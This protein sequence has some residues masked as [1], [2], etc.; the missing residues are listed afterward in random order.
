MKAYNLTAIVGH[1]VAILG[2][3][4]S[5]QSALNLLNLFRNQLVDLDLFD[6]THPDFAPISI[7]I[8]SQKQYDTIIVSPGVPLLRAHALLSKNS[9][10]NLMSEIDLASYFLDREVIIGITGSVGK[11]TTTS[12][13][14]AAL[15]VVDSEAF[16]GGNLGT[17][18]C[19]Y[20][21]QIIKGR[22]RS[23]YIAL[24][25]SS[26]QLENV[27]HLKL[28]VGAIT[29]LV[30]N[31]LERYENKQHYFETKTS[32]INISKSPVFLN[33][34]GGELWNYVTLLGP[35]FLPIWTSPEMH[36]EFDF[37]R[38]RLIGSYN[39]DNAA[40]AISILKYLK[41]DPVC[42]SAIQEFSGLPHRLELVVIKKEITYIN[43]SKA[44]AVQSILDAV[45]AVLPD[46]K[47][48]LHLLLGGR[49][50][51]LDWEKLE[52]LA[53][54]KNIACYFFG[55]SRQLIQDK[56]QLSGKSYQ[57]LAACLS[58][59][60]NEP[61]CGDTVLLSPGGTSL[62]EFKSFEHRGDE[63]KKWALQLTT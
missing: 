4:K 55:E 5:G 22:A 38:M 34:A 1:K 21:F 24:E 30:P 20:A 41:I 50:K 61:Q 37:S 15:N 7:E 32:I 26:Y 27:K 46:T 45:R 49:D 35:Q 2:M 16:I 28:T 13:L 54:E 23:Q 52:V 3:G 12:L 58:S 39:H 60:A 11:S 47:G 56:S 57:S 42:F 48:T 17:P 18:L 40:L 8:F 6:D 51:K 53:Q 62:D 29:S 63:F 43:D 14:G 10:T 31:H 25:L 33:R 59:I 19:D 36:P 9:S 44:T